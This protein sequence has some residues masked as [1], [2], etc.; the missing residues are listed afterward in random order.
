[1]SYR[2]DKFGDGRTDGRTDRQTQAMTKPEGQHWPRVKMRYFIEE[3]YFEVIT[4][5]I[6]NAVV[7]IYF[8]R[9]LQYADEI[10]RKTNI[11]EN[12]KEQG[13]VSM[14]S[15]WLNDTIRMHK[16][17]SRLA[18]IM[19]LPGGT[20]PLP[21]PISIFISEVLPCDIHVK[22]ISKW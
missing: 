13:T 2:A 7:N 21:E 17:G 22:T 19:L 1:M 4:C 11:S 3:S 8:I 20:K 14:N 16:S 15:L 12:Q 18:W 5:N 9:I 6:C 10:I